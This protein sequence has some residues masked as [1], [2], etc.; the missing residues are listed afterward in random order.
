MFKTDIEATHSKS[1]K[2]KKQIEIN[3]IVNQN[4]EY[5]K[6][7]KF[8]REK[9]KRRKAE[10]REIPVEASDADVCHDPKRAKKKKSKSKR[11]NVGEEEQDSKIEKKI[12]KKS[13]RESEIDKDI[14]D[15]L[16]KKKKRKKN[17]QPDDVSDPQNISEQCK[18]NIC[19]EDPS[20]IQGESEG[21]KKK[22]RKNNV[23]MEGGL[24][25]NIKTS[26]GTPD[27]VCKTLK[28]SCVAEASSVK[29]RKKKKQSHSV[30]TNTSEDEKPMKKRKRDRNIDEPEAG[31]DNLK[32]ADSRRQKDEQK[33]DNL[34]STTDR[35]HAK[36]RK[37][38]KLHTEEP[39]RA[40]KG[41]TLPVEK[42]MRVEQIGN[43]MEYS[44]KSG[45]KRKRLIEAEGEGIATSDRERLKLDAANSV[46]KL[47][48][49]PV[50]TKGKKQKTTFNVGESVETEKI[51]RKKKEISSGIHVKE[52]LCDDDDLLIMSEKKGNIFEVKIDKARRQ[53][54]QEEIDRESGK[55][56]TLETKVSPEIKPRCTGTQWDTATFESTEQKNKFLR[57]MGGFKS[58][59]PPQSSSSGKHN[60]ALNRDQEEK[61]NRTLQNEFDRALNLRQNRGIGLGFIPLSS[62][63]NKTFFIDK[64]ASRS[65]KFDFD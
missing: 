46:C 15:G 39:E 19:E 63:S 3:I 43:E 48:N 36:K 57:L 58:S 16:K 31:S 1:V 28:I 54:L 12:S 59:N 61:F 35:T 9:K 49:S 38:E 51:K 30:D 5:E 20:R 41:E 14:S 52:E 7:N 34:S 53:A 27:K 44:T 62:Q 50:T 29:K 37:K 56:G 21:N 64:H 47:Q 11:S 18:R 40:H 2:S 17:I 23:D 32:V 24:S 13:P 45:K 42:V 8:K 6:K 60:M 33:L 10:M 65:T 55:T 25:K 22:K 4:Q 26:N